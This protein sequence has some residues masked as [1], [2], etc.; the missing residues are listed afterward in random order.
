MFSSLKNLIAP[1]NIQELNFGVYHLVKLSIFASIFSLPW[2]IA[3]VFIKFSLS[4]FPIFAIAFL[5]VIPNI[6]TIMA[7]YDKKEVSFKEYK[8]EL[9]QNYWHK[10]KYAIPFILGA[11]FYLIDSYILIYKMNLRVLFPVLYIT[12]MFLVVA[13]IYFIILR[14]DKINGFKTTVKMAAFISWRQSFTSLII[15][16]VVMLWLSIGYF[17]QGLNCIFGSAFLWGIIFK[18]SQR[19]T[20]KVFSTLN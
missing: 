5:F 3:N 7:F 1:K 9:K 11:N 14:N 10:M 17:V 16:L 18:L 15:F 2:V 20:K 8:N 12:L 13:S 19:K 4:T 6:L